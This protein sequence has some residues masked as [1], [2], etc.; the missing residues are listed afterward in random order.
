MAPTI[1][2]PLHIGQKLIPR[3]GS[4]LPKASISDFVTRGSGIEWLVT[5][6]DDGNSQMLSISQIHR[7]YEFED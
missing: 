2:P 6:E 7:Y 5:F 1:H 3:K 4:P